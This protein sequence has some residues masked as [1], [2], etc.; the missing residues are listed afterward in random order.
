MNQI[1][2]CKKASLIKENLL[3]LLECVQRVFESENDGLRTQAVRAVESF[4]TLPRNSLKLI[5][6]SAYESLVGFLKKGSITNG[7]VVAGLV[8]LSRLAKSEPN[9]M[10]SVVSQFEFVHANLPPTLSVT[11]VQNV[12]KIMKIQLMDIVRTSSASASP[13]LTN[14]S[15]LV[16]DL[17]V[18]K[19]DFEK[20]I[21]SGSGSGKNKRPRK[22]D[23]SSGKGSAKNTDENPAKKSRNEADKE[24]DKIEEL[25]QLVLPQLTVENVASLVIS[26][27]KMLPETIPASFS[28]TYTPINSAGTEPQKKHLARLLA[29]QMVQ[30]GLGP[31]GEP[32]REGR[33]TE[34]AKS[35]EHKRW[36]TEHKD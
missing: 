21:S 4:V 20:A 12:R 23:S 32:E 26:S 24:K 35:T 1:H 33:R 36:R 5:A 30:A 16:F 15:Q 13:Y 31:K 25:A 2:A 14:I 34:K 3:A 7:N 29:T 28:A 11:Q 8:S 6:D 9:L 10:T 19:S 22:D 18:S 27:M 17:G